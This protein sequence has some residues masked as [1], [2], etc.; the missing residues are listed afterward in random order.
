VPEALNKEISNPSTEPATPQSASDR[1]RAKARELVAKADT[2]PT[3]TTVSQDHFAWFLL[4]CP[5]E[6][7]REPQRALNLAKIVTRTVPERLSAWRTQSLAHYRLGQWHEA[8]HA[9]QT[10]LIGSSDESLDAATLYL[11]AM[12]EWQLGDH[13]EARQTIEL[14]RSRRSSDRRSD[15]GEASL[16]AEAKALVKRN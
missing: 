1:Y 3:R 12:I 16:A 8:E 4:T 10:L 5:D 2:V 9:L 6:T 7:F 11:R 13:A 14:A 15:S